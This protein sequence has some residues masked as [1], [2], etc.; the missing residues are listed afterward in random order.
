[1]E[2]NDGSLRRRDFY[3]G[4]LLILLALAVIGEATTYPMSDS[5]GGV[6][7]VWFVSPA[8]F[9]I[10]VGSLLLILALV[11]TGNAIAY[12]GWPAVLW[13]R[14]NKTERSKSA[15]LRF[16]SVVLFFC[17]FVYVYIPRVDFFIASAMFLYTFIG[18]FYLERSST[19]ALN[20]IYYCVIA[21]AVLL[22]ADA[23]A[24]QSGQWIA[25]GLTS[26]GLILLFLISLK[27]CKHEP[28]CH[29]RLKATLLVALLVP[30]ILT[31]IFRFG[32]LVPLPTE[33]F[34]I[35]LMEQLKYLLR[36]STLSG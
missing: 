20:S 33:G 2:G 32:L 24:G 25:D 31:P 9:P 3:T 13:E 15:D 1:M 30:L 27:A 21:G 7:N 29:R 10:L 6:Q 26:A 35:E 19:L 8:L 34:Y 5:Y 17:A 14:Q 36:S 23:D 22:G 28:E 16:I 11:L 18:G 4:I 12:H